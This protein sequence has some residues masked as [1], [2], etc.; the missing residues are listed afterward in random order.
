MALTRVLGIIMTAL[1]VVLSSACSAKS[2]QTERAPTKSKYSLAI[3]G[4]NYTDQYIDSY[5]VNGTGG[6]NIFVSGP[7]TGGG[8][9]AC[10]TSYFPKIKNQS[11][12]VRWQSGGCKYFAGLGAD[13]KDIWLI[14]PEF[15]EA[16]A[17][18]IDVSTS[19]PQNMEIHIY[20]NN[21]VEAYVTSEFSRPRMKL[22]D[23]RGHDADFPR[24]Q[25]DKKPK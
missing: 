7:T 17:S 24:C 20:P 21:K 4:Y 8:K 12:H 2:E 9:L 15:K 19:E 6:G 22:E 10:C 5:S 11:V 25:N 18:V 13:G 23:N 16:D 3:I 1:A 14:H